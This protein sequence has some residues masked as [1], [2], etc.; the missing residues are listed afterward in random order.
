VGLNLKNIRRA[1][2][3]LFLTWTA[4]AL[5]GPLWWGLRLQKRHL[6]A[7]Y[8][9][10][11]GGDLDAVRLLAQRPLASVAWLQDL[12]LDQNATA[13]SRVEAINALVKKNALH[14]EALSIL[15]WIDQPLAVR[16]AVAN[17]FQQHGCDEVCVGAALN[18]LNAI[19]KGESTFE[20]RLSAQRPDTSAMSAR[21]DE[22]L[23]RETVQDYLA[24]L[25][26]D[27]CLTKQ[28]LNKS[29]P[30]DHTFVDHV[31]VKVKPC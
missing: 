24:L 27:P 5:C 29:Y 2:I 9:S 22:E 30:K 16:H 4:I 10:A 13:D 25:N 31:C 17:A 8:T 18:A 21:I 28:K 12:A 15:L 19:W 3:V 26:L 11:S 1:Q 7:L 14:S 20:M 6:H 23:H